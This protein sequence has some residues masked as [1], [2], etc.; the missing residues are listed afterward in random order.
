LDVGLEDRSAPHASG[1]TQEPL[2][3]ESDTSKSLGEP[4]LLG[5]TAHGRTTALAVG[6]RRGAQGCGV[7]ERVKGD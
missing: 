6:P 5:N 2:S 4:N 1:R 7:T 3:V